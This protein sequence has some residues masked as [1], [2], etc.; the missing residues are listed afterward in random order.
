VPILQRLRAHAIEHTLFEPT[1]LTAAIGRLGFLQADPIRS[2]ARAQD[3]ILRHRVTGYRV[4]D[5][6]ALYPS[7]ELEEGLLY[8]YGFLPRSNWQWLRPRELGPMPPLDRQVLEMLRDQGPMHPSELAERF[9]NDRVVNAWGG[10]SR[11]TKKALERLHYRGLLRIARRDRGVRVYETA[12]AMAEPLPPV[13]RFRALV[14]LVA[15]VLAP[16][17]EKT[18]RSIAARLRRTV[19]DVTDHLALLEEL[20]SDGT[21]SRETIDGHG[22]I[23]P[24]IERAPR[25]APR[26]V[27]FL[28]PFDPLVWDRARFEHLF[29]W[30][31]RFEAYTPRA[32]RTRGYYA[33]P[34]LFGDRVVGWANLAVVDGV[35]NVD[36]GFVEGRPGDTEFETELDDEIARIRVFLEPATRYTGS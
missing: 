6:E 2:P 15:N 27:R 4:D 16:V 9:G 17:L 1:T 19:L 24:P 32:K 8:A 30:A 34:V 10:Y 11:A 21:L 22:Y 13:V 31:Y 3:L 5:L 28:A 14:V 36:L 33:M 25:Q 26:R 7:L 18:L 12:P 29:G 35:L 20:C 23:S